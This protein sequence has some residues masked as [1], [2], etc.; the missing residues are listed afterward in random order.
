MEE[1]N[2]INDSLEGSEPQEIYPNLSSTPEHETFLNESTA[3]PTIQPESRQREVATP[4][5]DTNQELES[6]DVIQGSHESEAAQVVVPEPSALLSSPASE[7]PQEQPPPT[8]TELEP[9]LPVRPEIVDNAIDRMTQEN[10]ILE[11]EQ[12]EEESVILF[13]GSLPYEATED[14][15]HK[16]FS[17]HGKV[18][19]VRIISD[20]YVLEFFVRSNGLVS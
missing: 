14:D 9:P 16:L 2:P 13:V 15:L 5:F 3:P 12:G 18:L 1:L 4:E 8:Q 11:N 19:G 7:L 10:P 6:S 17:P 20:R